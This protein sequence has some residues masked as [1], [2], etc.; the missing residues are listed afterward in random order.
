MSLKNRG[1]GN[2]GKKMKTMKECLKKIV[3]GILIVTLAAG[4]CEDI[5]AKT[6]YSSTTF[7]STGEIYKNEYVPYKGDILEI[8][9]SYI[10]M[11]YSYQ[12]QKRADFNKDG[13]KERVVLK[14]RSS[15]N[16]KKAFFKIKINGKIVKKETKTSLWQEIAQFKTY[17]V[18]GKILAV[19]LYGDED[20]A[21]GGA[22][23]YEW[24]G[25]NRLR[26]LKAYK[27][28]GYLDVYIAR[29]KKLKRKVLYIEDTQQL[30]NHGDEKWPRNVLK[31]YQDYADDERVSVTKTTYNKFVYKNGFLKKRGRDITYEVGL[32]YD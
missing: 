15:K 23:I 21:G 24:K 31:R 30:F 19:L 29:D 16:G 28:K 1:K 17:E 6:Y 3:I 22:V 32:G 10:A 2:T 20:I 9:E 13:I 12:R 27:A 26:E 7:S 8:S 5:E 14:A 18:Q 25:K 4:A 11:V